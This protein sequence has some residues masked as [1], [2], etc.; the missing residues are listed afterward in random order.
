MPR[1]LSLRGRTKADRSSAAPVGEPYFRR[2]QFDR[3][4]YRERAALMR[5]PAAPK[6]PSTQRRKAIRAAAGKSRL[7]EAKS[8]S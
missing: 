8:L 7:A 4:V 6:V 2:A 5:R 1:R 3:Y